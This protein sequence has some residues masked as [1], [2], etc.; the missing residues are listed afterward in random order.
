MTD[1]C[2]KPTN[3]LSVKYLGYGKCTEPCM[4]FYA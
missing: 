1:M 4:Q 2:I 3:M